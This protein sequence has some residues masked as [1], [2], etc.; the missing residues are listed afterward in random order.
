MA[1]LGL[2]LPRGVRR[3]WSCWLLLLPGPVGVP[4]PGIPREATPGRLLLSRCTQRG[5]SWWTW[6]RTS[7]SMT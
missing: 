5:S 2:G 3:G 1:L 6:T 4:Q 7:T